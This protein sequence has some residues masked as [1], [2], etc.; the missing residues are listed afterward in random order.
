MM[1]RHVPLEIAKITK[2]LITKCSI[3]QFLHVF[4]RKTFPTA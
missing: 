4:S 3:T 2:I 1:L